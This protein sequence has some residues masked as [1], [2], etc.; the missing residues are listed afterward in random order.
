[1]LDY[2]NQ[3]FIAVY[4]DLLV[5]IN[6]TNALVDCLNSKEA[7]LEVVEKIRMEI[8]RRDSLSC[9]M[10]YATALADDTKTR[11]FDYQNGDLQLLMV[12][13]QTLIVDGRAFMECLEVKK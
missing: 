1:M 12:H 6:D 10:Q 2:K 3:D 5:L 4:Q 13:V 9:M 11:I 8:R 7:V